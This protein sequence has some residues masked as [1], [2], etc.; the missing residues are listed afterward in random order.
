[1]EDPEYTIE[2]AERL[3]SMGVMPILSPLRPLDGTELEDAR[4]F[5]HRT[6]FDIYVEVHTRAMHY[7][8]PTGPT[9]IP[10]QNNTLAVPLPGDTYRFY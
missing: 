9:C 7:G 1:L 8:I 3:A 2:G 5:D 10:C 4:G 6:Y